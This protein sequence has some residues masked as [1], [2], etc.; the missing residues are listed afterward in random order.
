M[1]L[2]LGA[3]ANSKN[4]QGMS[5]I[6]VALKNAHQALINQAIEYGADLYALDDDGWNVIHHAAK[7]QW[8]GTDSMQVLV[9][10]HADINV[11]SVAGKTP[12]CIAMRHRNKPMVAYLSQLNVKQGNCE[13]APR[14]GVP[15]QVITGPR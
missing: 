6:V 5:L 8:E 2:E 15:L 14:T 9:A 1:L 13:I 10:A 12:L 3:D 7:T 4:D 11:L